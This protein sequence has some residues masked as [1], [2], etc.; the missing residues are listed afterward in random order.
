M[1]CRWRALRRSTAAVLLLVGA[2]AAGQVGREP[3][4][5][6]V[7]DV[8]GAY[9]ELL[10]ILEAA[11]LTDAAGHWVGRDA[12]LV[13]TGDILDR[14]DGVVAVVDLL[15]RLQEEAM[16]AGGRVVALLGNHEQLNLL[17]DFR[18][19]SAATLATFVQADSAARRERAWESWVAWLA[20]RAAARGTRP[21]DPESLREG[22]LAEHPL[23]LLE[24][25][26][27]MGPTGRFGPWLR[28]LP[29]AVQLGDVL[30]LHGGLGPAYVD[31]PLEDINTRSRDLLL[32]HDRIREALVANGVI[33]PFFTLDEVNGLV[34]HEAAT[35]LT[36][37]EF[38]A[39]R[40]AVGEAAAHLD[41]L[42]QL[43]LADSPLW[44]RGYSR[45]DEA[46]LRPIA[47]AL[48]ANHGVH[49]VVTA[50][51]P[52]T[53]SIRS[54][55]GGTFFQ[56]DTGMLERVYHGRPSA[57]EI[58]GGRFTAVY[59]RS[60]QVLLD[61][62]A[63]A[64]LAGRSEPVRGPAGP[65]PRPLL[66]AWSAEGP[67]PEEA[68][69]PRWWGLDGQPLPF[70]TEEEVEEFL[71]SAAILEIEDIPE[72][73]TKP[74]KAVLELGTVRAHA[75]FRYHHDEGRGAKLADGTTQMFF[76]DSY[77]NEVVA[78]ELS[79]L[80]GMTNVPPAVIRE[81]GG[82]NGSLQ[83]WIENGVTQKKRQAE[84]LPMPAEF[85]VRA[86]RQTADMDIF[87]NLINNTDRNA[88]NI[89]W[90]PDW[91]L[92]LIDHTRAF[93]RSTTLV[94]PDEVTR[95]S[96]P[97]WEAMLALDEEVV[98]VRLRP[99]L[100]TFEIR[101]LLARRDKLVKALEREIERRGETAVIFEPGEATPAVAVTYEES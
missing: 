44:F 73:V 28:E 93:A 31:A 5:V 36:G 70:R 54:R 77:K 10:T 91:N 98:T 66:V 83:L 76:L 96:R 64:T 49:H 22:W 41:E 3:R 95:C 33:L 74:Q 65:A 11:G 34:R 29:V 12:V 90:G 79:R 19:V 84:S 82:R 80:L 57:L 71:R 20:E 53:S 32:A 101:G 1:S 88:G 89:L 99:Y 59:P 8:H 30:F 9:E 4:I 40:A 42:Q 35:P 18:D 51:S 92:W 78:Y 100:G 21:G 97:L 7:G 17:S 58:S 13:Q 63:D 60:R 81:I 27:A 15:R 47:R 24:Y 2:P 16:A 50:H 6:A 43:L 23:G 55:L 45:L 61:R 26:E 72:G 86:N 37:A 25:Q 69:T 14:G 75:A 56:I 87:D 46:D 48:A 38:A 62:E 68:S 67:P 85:V 39:R 94:R 52:E